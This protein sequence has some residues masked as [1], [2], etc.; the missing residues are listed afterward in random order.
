MSGATSRGGMLPVAVYRSTVLLLW[1]LVVHNTLVSRALFWDGASFVANMLELRTFHDFYPAREHIAWLTQTPVLLLAELGVRDTRLLSMVFSF[2]AFGLPTAFYH[3]ALARTRGEP[4]LQAAVLFVIAAIYLPTCF[5]IV[6]E[7]NATYAAATAA[8]AVML[9]SDGRQSRVDAAILC[10]LGLVCIASYEAMIYLGLFL[11]SAAL[12]WVGRKPPAGSAPDPIARLLGLVAAIAFLAG[13]AVAAHAVIEY[14]HNDYFIRVRAATFDFWQ[15][16]QFVV[17]ATGLGMLALLCFVRP[18]LLR[19]W[20][21]V[22][23]VG[24][25]AVVL[26]ATPLYRLL[27]AEA[28]LFP[29]AH[30]IARTAAGGVFVILFAVLWAYV[31]WR[32]H[33]PALL[34]VLREPAV[35]RRLATAMFVLVLAAAV[36]DFVL[37]RLWSNYLAYFR[38]VVTSNTGVVYAEGLPLETWPNRLFFQDWSLPALSAI[39]RSAP[40]QGVIAIK[41]TYLYNPPFDPSCGT[42]PRLEGFA[43]RD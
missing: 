31:A 20:G 6:G 27:S 28:M 21:P 32:R 26:A 42:V 1:A 43:W 13:A 40:G 3:L 35:G 30:Y 15:N 29:P 8:M 17:T 38:S 39:V 33:P 19:G 23:L 10:G 36:P 4:T 2:A 14:W 24:L 22:A 41:K 9:T 5:F 37:T 25:T 34:A 11:A 7:Y 16:L 18:S 12:W